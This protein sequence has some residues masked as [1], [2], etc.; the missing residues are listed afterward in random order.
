MRSHPE[1]FVDLVLDKHFAIHIAGRNRP[2]ELLRLQRVE[3]YDPIILAAGAD[4]VVGEQNRSCLQSNGPAKGAGCQ[5]Y[6]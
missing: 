3:C 4:T 5:D 2:R 6:G 1:H